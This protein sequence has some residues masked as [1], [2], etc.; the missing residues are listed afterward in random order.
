MDTAAPNAME[1]SSMQLEGSKAPENLRQESLQLKPGTETDLPAMGDHEEE[2]PV[3]KDLDNETAETALLT[4]ND[5]DFD[6]K[7][8]LGFC[9][10]EVTRKTLEATTQFFPDR[11]QS[12]RQEYP[13]HHQ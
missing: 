12:E 7:E 1:H 6:L 9:S 10:E 8:M 4:S 11:V 2:A 13:K 5:T 3:E